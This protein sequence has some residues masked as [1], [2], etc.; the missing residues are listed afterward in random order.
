M[1]GRTGKEIVKPRDKE[2]AE[3]KTD[4]EK[5]YESA[6]CDDAKKMLQNKL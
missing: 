2:T 3:M 6:V 4:E 1:D 5:G